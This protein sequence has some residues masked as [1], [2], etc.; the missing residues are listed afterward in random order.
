MTQEQEGKD[1]KEGG[2]V[3]YQIE[4]LIERNN[5]GLTHISES[6]RSWKQ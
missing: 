1:F 6:L 5:E 3:A 4:R 2:G